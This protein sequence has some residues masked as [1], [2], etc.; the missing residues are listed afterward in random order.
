M[1]A[2]HRRLVAEGHGRSR[3]NSLPNSCGADDFG[4]RLRCE[5]GNRN[6]SQ[7]KLADELMRFGVKLDPSAI[8]RIESG[9][10]EVKLREAA[11]I[12]RAM[13]MIVDDLVPSNREDEAFERF[14]RTCATA[15]QH[16]FKARQHLAK[17]AQYFRRAAQFVEVFPDIAAEIAAQAGHDRRSSP[18]GFLESYTKDFPEI[19]PDAVLDVDATHA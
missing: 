13:H 12:A 11:A 15:I 10:R 7:R 4:R 14:D 5:R 6:L 17:M 3:R 16:A 9:A 18:E 19:E 1:K 2:V 8:A